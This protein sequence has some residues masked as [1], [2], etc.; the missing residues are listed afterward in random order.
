MS[1]NAEV[2]AEL[3]RAK[4]YRKI[5]ARLV[6]AHGH[7]LVWVFEFFDGRVSELE[8]IEANRQRILEIAGDVIGK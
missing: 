2:R 3:K 5:A 1:A 6:L 7:K 8:A 4:H